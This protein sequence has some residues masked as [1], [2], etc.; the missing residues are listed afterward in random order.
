M[1]D[2][3]I[4][5]RCVTFHLHRNTIMQYWRLT[6]SAS[7][8]KNSLPA[9]LQLRDREA[10]LSANQQGCQQFQ[11]RGADWSRDY[12]NIPHATVR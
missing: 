12:T 9:Q 2:K 1:F 3:I 7:M 4:P 8:K 10:T 5:R 11:Y 6:L